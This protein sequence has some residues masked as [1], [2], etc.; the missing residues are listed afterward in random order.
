MACPGLPGVRHGGAREA[1]SL[2]HSAASLLIFAIDWQ[3]LWESF[4]QRRVSAI[5]VY[6]ID[7]RASQIR[8]ARRTL[9]HFDAL[10]SS[11][12]LSPR[13]YFYRDPYFGLYGLA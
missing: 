11:F 6:Q 13:R 10:D 7:T 12:K 2:S 5:R 3:L 1:G 8:A 4:L 9:R